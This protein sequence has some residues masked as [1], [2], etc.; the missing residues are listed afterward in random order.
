MDRVAV[1]HTHM[2][3][4]PCVQGRKVARGWCLPRACVYPATPPALC[5]PLC[6]LNHNSQALGVCL[7]HSSRTQGADT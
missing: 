7:T 3:K 1:Q 5:W 4:L 6:V 2:W